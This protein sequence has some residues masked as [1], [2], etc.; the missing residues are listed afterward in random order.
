[1]EPSSAED[2]NLHVGTAEHR[3][4]FTASMEPSSAEDGNERKQRELAA[5]KRASMEPSSAEDGNFR[6]QNGGRGW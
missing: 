6:G 3:I 2:G 1:M 5:A 4:E